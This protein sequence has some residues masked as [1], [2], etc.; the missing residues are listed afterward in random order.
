MSYSQHPID[1]I[2]WN[3]IIPP[4]MEHLTQPFVFEAK[5]KR[6][7]ASETAVVGFVGVVWLN[8]KR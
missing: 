3:G 6:P 1:T 4:D 7:P 8:R 2:P 5:V